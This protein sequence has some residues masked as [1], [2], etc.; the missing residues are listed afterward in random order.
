MR[1]RILYEKHVLYAGFDRETKQAGAK[2]SAAE[3]ERFG[4]SLEMFFSW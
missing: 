2:V 4:W 1:R 3:S